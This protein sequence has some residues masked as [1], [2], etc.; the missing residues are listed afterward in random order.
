LAG[1][2]S[3]IRDLDLEMDALLARREERCIFVHPVWLRTWLAEFGSDCEP[4][5]LD[6]SN[7]EVLAIAPLMR[8]ED[9]LTFVGDPSICDFVDVL[10]DPEKPS[11]AYEGLWARLCSEDWCELDLWGLPS[12]SATRHELTARARAAGYGVAEQLEA[13]S[14]R[15]AL[16]GS[17]EDYLASLGKKDRHELRRKLRRLLDGGTRVELEVY[18]EQ[19]EVLAAMDIFFDLHTRSRQDKT[20]FMTDE[21]TSFFRR[22]ASSMSAEDLIRLFILYVDSK[23]VASVLCFDAG[24]YLYMYNSGYDPEFSSLSVGLVSKAL[25]IRWAIENGKQG[26]DFLRGNEP[27]KY[28]LGAQDQEIYRLIVRRPA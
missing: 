12:S 27:Y 14:P 19:H 5:F 17:W 25:C 21:M 18:R 7:S 15:I 13:V 10:V 2:T 11:E 26:L 1:A 23:P 4:F 8:R 20:E 6:V 28:D 3:G 16:P 22:M 24:S 9:C